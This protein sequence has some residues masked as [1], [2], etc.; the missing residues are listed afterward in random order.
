MSKRLEI[1]LTERPYVNSAE[2]YQLANF[3]ENIQEFEGLN[4]LRVNHSR[5]ASKIEKVLIAL[6]GSKTPGSFSL[7]HPYEHPS[8]LVD[9]RHIQL[10][11]WNFSHLSVKDFD[12]LIDNRQHWL[13]NILKESAF[14]HCRLLDTKFSELQNMESIQRYEALGIDHSPL[15]KKN[16]GMIVPF[17]TEIVDTSGNPGYWCFRKGYIEAVGSE[18]WLG[19]RFFERVK[20]SPEDVLL[21]A[22]L[23]TE[24][25]EN[26]V[27]YLKAYDKPFDSAEG[28]QAEI[29]FKLREL[30]FSNAINN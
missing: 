21:C 28:E 15:P 4:A 3:A 23:E 13:P 1:I 14:I 2:L 5:K 25:L 12:N 9:I 30:L 6:R 24:Q 22:W 10:T 11:D 26:D 7:E 27:V 18:M 17:N 16:N 8:K 29:Q 20:L 19:K